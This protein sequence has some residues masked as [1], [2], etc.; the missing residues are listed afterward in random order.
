MSRALLQFGSGKL[1]LVLA[2]TITLDSES[3]DNH[4]LIPLC[5]KS[6]AGM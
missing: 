4:S 6:G 5:H 2:N 1:L 3:H